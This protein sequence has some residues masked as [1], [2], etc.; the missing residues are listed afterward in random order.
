[1]ASESNHQ[2]LVEGAFFAA[3]TTIIAL[4]GLYMPPLYI[5][6]SLL[7][8]LPLAVLVRRR[9]LKTGFMA[10]LVAGALLFMLF[11]RPVAVVLLIIQMGP[12]GL[13]LGLLFKNYVSAGFSVVIA[14]LFS[15]VLLVASLLFSFWLTGINPFIMGPEMAQ[16]MDQVINTYKQAGILDQ[17]GEKEARLIIENFIRFMNLL[18]P[19]ILVM[20]SIVSTF[21]TY[22]INRQVLLRLGYNVPVLPPFSRWRFPWYSIW[23]IILGLSLILAGDSLGMTVMNTTGKNLL[24]VVGFI[25][26]ILGLSVASYFIKGWKI[27]RPVKIIMVVMAFLYLPFMFSVLLTLGVMDTLLNTRRLSENNEEE[28]KTK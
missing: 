3:L 7:T 13:L 8:P 12:L 11:G 10:M 26:T 18:L 15:A 1:M 27:A 5:V 23:G 14:G 24:L 19:G 20:S 6:T 25:Y 2:A 16:S 22:L 21:V 4:V 17:T 9:D 28:G